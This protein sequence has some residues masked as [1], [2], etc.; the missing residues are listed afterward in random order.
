MKNF[1]LALLAGTLAALAA[2][3]DQTADQA[4]PDGAATQRIDGTTL[5]WSLP[6]TAR[7]EG[8]RLI[9]EVP[10]GDPERLVEAHAQCTA[11]LDLS[12]FL[13]GGRG[14]HLSV[15]VRA[16]DVTKPDYR[17]N[18]VKCMFRYI[19]DATG[20][21]AHPGAVLPIGS[22]D[23]RTADLHL[24]FLNT[25]GLPVDGKATLVLGLQGC[26]G[27][28]EFDLSSLSF[29]SEDVGVPFAEYRDYVVEYPEGEG[30]D[31]P[32]RRRWRGCMSPGGRYTTEEDVET[33][34]RWG[35]TLIRY[36][37]N[38]NWWKLDDNQDLDEYARW[39]DW[40]LDN[41]EDVL[42]WCEA[43][44]MKVCIDLH[45]LPG[46]KWGEREREPLEMNMFSDDRYAAAFVDT[47]RRIAARYSGHPALYGY[48]LVNEPSQRRPLRHSF[49]Q[50]Q[51]DAARAIREIDPVTPIVFAGNNASHADDFRY[52]VPIPLENVIYQVH[53][54]H[55][56]AFTHQGVSGNARSTPE[57]PITW[58]GVDP[59]TGEVWNKD[60]LR[61]KLQPVRDFQLR[62][63]ARIFV[64]EFSA[65]AW[66]RGAENYLRDCIELFEEYGWDWTYH[67]FREAP[68]WDVE[69]EGETNP[70]IRPAAEDTPRKKALL[71]G[72]R[73]SR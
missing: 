12:P 68:C 39:V 8:E 30:P 3:S 11:L 20:Q 34:H 69:Q 14:L 53:C 67:A 73:R 28:A 21:L 63:K 43:R 61:K 71:E 62:H 31:D 2:A 70:E 48:D 42:R 26:S 7:I 72:F 18:G 50:I 41:V 59:R 13:A 9:V 15:R 33:L 49:W 40:R 17:W 25:H 29:V 47:W 10:K 6:P 1:S 46:G 51:L 23:W 4:V 38:R 64:G 37:I 58:P 57:K 32:G 5:A 35:A 22:F 56:H 66:A 55:P 16:S 27:R 24:N 19:S 52:L 36:Q 54:Y 44:G 45:A 65:A 60:W